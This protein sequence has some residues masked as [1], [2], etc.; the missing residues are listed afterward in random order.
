MLLVFLQFLLFTSMSTQAYKSYPGTAVARMLASRA[1]AASLT[2][3]E[4]TSDWDSVTR[5][6]ILWA[7]GLKDLRSARPGQGYTGHAF[8]DW[9]H[10]DATCMM[11]FITNQTNSDGAVVGIS[12]KNNLHDGILVA[13]DP[14]L[15]EGG[16]WSTCQLGCNKDPPSDVAHV[17]FKSRI[18]FK[19]VWVPPSF[20][21][22]V[23]VDDDGN[24]IN[25]GV[26]VGNIPSEQER[27]MNYEAV[28][29]SKYAVHV[30]EVPI[31]VTPSL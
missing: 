23:L 12:K 31:D 9:N 21:Q 18:A 25:R 30:T 16:S 26:G 5:P 6:R 7:A 4:L 8:N 13:S 29:G 1:R 10:V 27:Q 24:V 15:G 11:P 19:L 2:S 20:T 3:K 22:F 28:K 17:Q 14:E